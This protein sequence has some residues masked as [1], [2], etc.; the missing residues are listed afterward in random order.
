MPTQ[1]E[2]LAAVE[3]NLMQFKTETVRAYQDMAMQITMLKGLTEPTIGRLASMQWQIDQRF[4]IVDTTLN[5]HTERMKRIETTLD[6][7][8]ALLTEQKVLLTEIL[9]RLP[10][11]PWQPDNRNRL[12]Y[13]LF[14]RFS[15]VQRSIHS[16]TGNKNQ[17][18]ANYEAAAKHKI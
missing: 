9:T 18:K 5:E 10:Q 1:E 4:N 2:R 16:T 17:L 3:Q 15:F 13:N 14:R 8:A 11:K 7:Q 6:G 12:S